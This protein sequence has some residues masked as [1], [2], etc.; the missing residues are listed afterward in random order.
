MTGFEPAPFCSQSRRDTK[1]R[2]IPIIFA[3]ALDMNRTCNPQIRSLILY[4][5]ELRAHSLSKITFN[6]LV[7]RLRRNKNFLSCWRFRSELNR[8]S[9][10]CS[11]LPCHLATEPANKII[12][13]LVILHKMDFNR[14][15]FARDEPF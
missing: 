14:Q 6:I 13:L 7:L 12:S 11:Q 15:V 1:L 2:Y 10:S 4:P 9:L 3:G 8:R 5:V